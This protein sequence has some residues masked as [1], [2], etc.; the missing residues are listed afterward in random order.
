MSMIGKTVRFVAGFGLGAGIGALTALLLAPQSGKMSTEQIQARVQGILDAGRHAARQREEELYTAWEA[1]LGEARRAAEREAEGG[2]SA[3]DVSRQLEKARR[4]AH[5]REDKAR[6]EARKA[7][8]E[9]QKN[10]EKARANLDK[11]E[12]SKS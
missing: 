5:E 9:A 3:D 10:L 7:Q 2:K 11:V 12:D 4:E 1:E 6:E 8:E